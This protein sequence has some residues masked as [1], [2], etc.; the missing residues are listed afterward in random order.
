M[1][2][3]IGQCL[4]ARKR[5]FA[6]KVRIGVTAK[7]SLQKRFLDLAGLFGGFFK[8]GQMTEHRPAH[9]LADDLK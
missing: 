4:N 9:N 3:K 7:D 6:A 8:G 5:V 2:A 1:P